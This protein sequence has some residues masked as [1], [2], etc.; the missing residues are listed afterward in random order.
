[1]V[2]FL[3]PDGSGTLGRFAANGTFTNVRTPWGAGTFAAWSQVVYFDNGV[4]EHVFFYGG[5]T[6]LVGRFD[7]WTGNFTQEW[8]SNA[9]G[10][11]TH[12]AVSNG[13]L[14]FYKASTGEYA[15]ATILGDGTFHTLSSGGFMQSGWSTVV[16]AGQTFLL[17]HGSD[18]SAALV[19]YTA[20]GLETLNTWP[21]GTF[22]CQLLGSNANG[23]VLF[24]KSDHS[25]TARGFFSFGTTAGELGYVDLRT[26]LNE[27]SP[28]SDILS[29]GTLPG[30][31][32]P[33]TSEDSYQRASGA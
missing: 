33:L 9:F 2:L 11:W 14:M 16:A 29:I 7:P 22:V 6:G 12:I 5:S 27:F 24:L 10:A 26:Y 30:E 28:W 1:M 3:R 25:G 21:A 15:I 32:G 20:T 8:V 13:Y 4:N 23:V 31:H 17:F 18:G 19:E